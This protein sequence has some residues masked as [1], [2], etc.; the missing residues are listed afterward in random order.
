LAIGGELNSVSESRF[1]VMHKVVGATNVALPNEPAWHELCVGVDRNPCP[2]IAAAL[3]F[4]F[5]G[6][7]PILRV[8][9]RPDFVA[10]D[11]FTG[12]IAKDLVLILGAGS[13]KIAKQLHNRCAMDSG[14][15][16]NRA[17]NCTTTQFREKRHSGTF[18]SFRAKSRNLWIPC[19][20]ASQRF[21][22]EMSRLRST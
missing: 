8:N 18:L 20:R 3:S 19:E 2:S 16:R 22:L 21:K 17:S 7:I 11:S 5:Y 4:L 10:L 13:A 14:H 12:K 9:K 1:Q 15:A 6:A